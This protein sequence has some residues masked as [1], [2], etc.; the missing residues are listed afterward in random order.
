MDVRTNQVVLSV[1]HG[2]PVED[3]LMFPS[4][5]MIVSCGGN[6][7]KVWDVLKGGALMRTLVHHHKT[8]TCMSFSSDY[9]YLLSGGLDR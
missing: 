6:V 2:E 4:S 5:N 7:I 3:V 1:T 8:I 9:K